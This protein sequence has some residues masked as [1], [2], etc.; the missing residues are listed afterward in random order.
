MASVSRQ[1]RTAAMPLFYRTI[2][3]DVDEAGFKTRARSSGGNRGVRTNLGLFVGA[4]VANV[5]RNMQIVVKGQ[6]QTAHQLA[7]ILRRIGLGETVWQGVERL[8]I[9]ISGCEFGRSFGR[10]E[11]GQEAGNTLCELLSLALPSL[12]DIVL[13][14]IGGHIYNTTAHVYQLIAER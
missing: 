6:L 3:I 9:D 13:L 7:R 5:V 14:G 1:W 12:S 10:R 11:N 2:I 4:N 8:R